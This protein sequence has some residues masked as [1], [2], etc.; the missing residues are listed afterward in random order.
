MDNKDDRIYLECVWSG[1]IKAHTSGNG[2]YQTGVPYK[3]SSQAKTE[4]FKDEYV[5]GSIIEF[6]GKDPNEIGTMSEY[7][8]DYLIV[9]HK[10]EVE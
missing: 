7:M 3:N 10:G 5:N 6:T 9:Q 4:P 2:I 8:V 1:N